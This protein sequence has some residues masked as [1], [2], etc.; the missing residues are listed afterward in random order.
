[1]RRSESLPAFRRYTLLLMAAPLLTGC[2]AHVRPV[3]DFDDATT[4]GWR[5]SGAVQ[6]DQGNAYTPMLFSLSHF[7][8]AQFPASFPGGDPLKDAKGALLVNGFQFDPWAQK[9]GFPNTSEFWEISTYYTGLDAY[10]SPL[11]QGIKGVKLAIGD[12]YGAT[13]G[14]VTANVGIRVRV[15][16]QDQL[17]RELDAAGKPLFHPVN[18]ASTGKWSV[19]S[20]SL[21]VPPGADVYLVFVMIRG[22]WKNYHTY[23]GGIVIDQV[24]PMK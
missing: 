2:M 6:D 4:Q 21:D 8:A 22:D 17:V 20:A 10:G 7:E 11:W 1:M 24:E 13:P 16:G 9:F 15:A 23:E 19:I 3:Y 18:H 12:M 14:H 5:L